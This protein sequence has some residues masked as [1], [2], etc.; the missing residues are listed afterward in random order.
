MT[1]CELEHFEDY[2]PFPRRG[3]QK[4]EP[5]IKLVAFDEIQLG[6]ERPYLVKD[7]IPRTGLSVIW[8]P[9]KSGKSFWTFD[10]SMHVALGWPYR[11]RR[12]QQGP[13]CYCAFEGQTGIKSRVEAFRLHH[14]EESTETVPFYLVPVILDLV[15]DHAELIAAIRTTLGEEDPVAVVLDTLNRSLAGSESSDTDMSAYVRAADAIR[16]AFNCAVLIVHHCG[17][18]DSRPRG[19]TSLTGAADAQ[20]SVKR[21]GAG[22]ILVTVE[23]RKDGQEGEAVASKLESVEVGSDEDGEPITSCVIVPAEMSAVS[24]P[25]TRMTANQQ[26]MLT[27]L[28]TGPISTE[29]W[30]TRAR[31]AGIGIKRKADLYD[32]RNALHR[33]GLV[34]EGVNGWSPKM[35]IQETGTEVVTRY[36]L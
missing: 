6:A 8:G 9:P 22:T 35:G 10:L 28:G 7:L 14:L 21:D 23:C 2:D 31:E 26:T 19:H 33:M 12:T 4:P 1:L 3:K 25:R 34:Y 27:L 20:L 29:E 15:K 17:I 16:E 11:G 18:N 5:R 36:G 30:N 13:V 32:I 24:V